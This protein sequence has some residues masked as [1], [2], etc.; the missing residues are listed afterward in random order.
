M[1]KFE[2]TLQ[3]EA[4]PLD[5][6]TFRQFPHTIHLRTV[7]PSSGR[8][9]RGSLFISSID[10]GNLPFVETGPLVKFT[11]HLI[12]RRR[13]P[14]IFPANYP[15]EKY[16]T[17]AGFMISQFEEKVKSIKRHV[18]VCIQANFICSINT[19]VLPFSATDLCNLPILLPHV[20]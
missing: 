14:A 8:L 3:L 17:R 16:Q 20:L 1:L 2:R 13:L 15:V 12:P 9:Q 5:K 18:H 7:R 10:D 6:E 4:L 19:S 11:I